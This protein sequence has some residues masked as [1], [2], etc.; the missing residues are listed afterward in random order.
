MKHRIIPA[1]LS[2]GAGTRLWPASSPA[3]PKQFHALASADS[4]LADTLARVRGQTEALSFTAPIVIASASHAELVA[5]QAG[6]GATIVLE[7]CARNTAAAAAVA[8]ALALEQEPAALVLLAPADHVVADRAAFLAAIARAAPFAHQRIVTFGMT[9]SRAETGYGYIKPG[10]ELG[11]GVFE[12]E[13]FK[14]KPVATLARQYAGDG[15]LWNAG[16]FLFS[17]ALLLRE[18]SAHP[19]I[20]N[21]CHR[22]VV[23]RGAERKRN[24]PRRSRVRKCAGAAAR[25]SGDGANQA[26]RRGSLRHRLDRCRRLG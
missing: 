20:S 12:I 2:G 11:V 10:A 22:R 17:P 21:P 18:F 9:P 15:H 24:P 25:H 16:M 5:A 3:K 14:E 23:T 8:A 13:A 19:E 6:A 26:W 4:L 7:P 1:I